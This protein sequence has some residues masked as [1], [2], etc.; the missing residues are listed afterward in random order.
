MYAFF[1]RQPLGVTKGGIS[2][3]V[4]MEL[5]FLGMT[6]YIQKWRGDAIV[7][8][9]N[10]EFGTE[11]KS[12]LECRERYLGHLTGRAPSDYLGLAK[13]I[14]DL[15]RIK[16]EFKK[17]T[18]FSLLSIWRAV[19]NKEARPR[20]LTLF[21]ACLSMMVA[22]TV[23]TDA[24]LE[25]L[26][27]AFSDAQWRNLML[28]VAMLSGLMFMA[29]V[30]LRLMAPSGIQVLAQWAIL[31]FKGSVFED[32]QITYFVRDLIQFYKPESSRSVEDKQLKNIPSPEGIS[33]A[34]VGPENVVGNAELEA[35]N[36]PLVPHSP[37]EV[38]HLAHTHS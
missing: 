24:S 28:L 19:Y 15:G 25:T 20:L 12:L 36:L 30:T 37:E 10:F 31:I 13:E 5:V 33:T 32:L 21:V 16:R 17:K 1:S 14:S 8:R 4:V 6:F 2:V 29:A 26:F 9:L 35:A 27:E 22:L 3:M 11:C 38:R 7:K 18:E 34:K 23:K